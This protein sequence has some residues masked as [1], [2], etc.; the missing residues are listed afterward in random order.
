MDETQPPGGGAQHDAL[1][2]ESRRERLQRRTRHVRL[3]GSAILLVLAVVVIVALIVAN[4]NQVRISWVFGHSR[5]SLVWIVVVA[6]IVGWIAG[7]A[8]SL[9]L[10]QRAR[11][12]RRD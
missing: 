12:R 11:A 2:A 1:G 5:A 4:T 6:A 8:T 10:R 9:V 3:Y 7:M